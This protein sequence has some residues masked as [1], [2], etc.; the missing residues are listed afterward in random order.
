MFGFNPFGS[1]YRYNLYLTKQISGSITH[2]TLEAVVE[3][4]VAGNDE[5]GAILY[6]EFTP[7]RKYF[8]MRL[9]PDESED[10]FHDVMLAVFRAVR[11]GG[12]RDP[13]SLRSYAWSAAQRILSTR[14]GTLITE[15]QS[16]EDSG[17]ICDS[18][19]DPETSA[20]RRENA[21]IAGRVLATL[22]KKHREVLI[23]YYLEGQPRE[24]IQAEM[25]L[26]PT[27]F[28]LIKSKAKAAL[29]LR[30]RRRL[31]DRPGVSLPVDAMAQGPLSDRND[32]KEADIK[33]L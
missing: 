1:V 13:R 18:A 33:L 6:R 3:L 14:L 7:I 11:L 19:P 23:R 4:V 2:E 8:A 30:L 16:V 31:S 22:P 20:I 12:I 32:L 5:A 9:P 26:T 15:R 21:E 10:R 29:T 25:S 24:R 27:Q 17:M 28:R